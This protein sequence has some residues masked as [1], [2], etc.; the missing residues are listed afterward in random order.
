MLAIL[1]M[2]IEWRK[3]SRSPQG[4]LQREKYLQPM[5]IEEGVNLAGEGIF[6]K[7]CSYYQKRDIV[8]HAGDRFLEMNQKLLER[9]RGRPFMGEDEYEYRRLRKWRQQ[10]EREKGAFYTM[11]KVEI[12]CVTIAREQG[13]SYRIRWFDDEK[14]MPRR[15]G[16]N[17][18][19]YRK[20]SRLAGRSNVLNETAFILEPGQSGLLK[21]NYRYT[22]YHGQWYRCYS[23]YLVNTQE[24][25]QDI[26][27][28]NYT[29]EYRQLAQLL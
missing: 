10:M 8:S 26:F 22:S 21:Y 29:F 12:P 1:W 19:F 25:V 9:D 15:K 20:G 6:L 24:L 11:E 5:K 3:E 4:A 23:I 14:G 7:K 28:R 13:D 17:E 27:M 16:R 18:E 2:T